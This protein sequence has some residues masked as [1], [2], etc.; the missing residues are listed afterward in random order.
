MEYALAVTIE[1]LTKSHD[2]YNEIVTEAKGRFPA[3][4]LVRIPVR[5]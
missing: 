2:I 5:R 3:V 4:E 1:D